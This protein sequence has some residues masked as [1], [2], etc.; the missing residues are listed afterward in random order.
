[1]AV[2]R[3]P[4]VGVR[5]EIQAPVQVAPELELLVLHCTMHGSLSSGCPVAELKQ[6]KR[7]WLHRM[8][9]H[10]HDRKLMLILHYYL[11][12]YS[13]FASFSTDVL[14]LFWESIQALTWLFVVMSLWS[15]L[16]WE[17]G[18]S[19]VFLSL[20]TLT[21]LKNIRYSFCRLSSHLDLSDVFSCLNW[22]YIHFG[23]EHHGNG[24]VLFS[25]HHKRRCVRSI[26]IIYRWCS[27]WSLG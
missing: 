18:S 14:P 21:F 24:A 19:L 2:L 22:G 1:M 4:I 5:A 13:N 12:L 27:F 11:L 26:C 17:A 7:V 20:M 25:V 9:W 23:Q 3:H 10:K 6:E 16:I 8:S 15:S